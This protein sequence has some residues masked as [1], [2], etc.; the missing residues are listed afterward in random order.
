M[1]AS[2]RLRDL[3]C[4]ITLDPPYCHLSLGKE[5]GQV[6]HFTDPRLAQGLL[7]LGLKDRRNTQRLPIS[8]EACFSLEVPRANA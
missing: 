6:C 4:D 8:L 5:I 3:I 7:D 1:S 2:K